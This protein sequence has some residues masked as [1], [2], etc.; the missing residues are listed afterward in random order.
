MV[1]GLVSEECESLLHKRYPDAL[2]V[3]LPFNAEMFNE[4]RRKRLAIKNRTFLRFW[5]EAAKIAIATYGD[6]HQEAFRRDVYIEGENI[7]SRLPESF[8]LAVVVD[9]E[10][11]ETET[12][13]H[14][15]I[16]PK[17]ESINELLRPKLEKLT[18]MMQRLAQNNRVAA[19]DIIL[20]SGKSSALPVVREVIEKCFA[21]A[22]IAPSRESDDHS[23]DLKECVVRGACELS[24][25]DP[26]AKV[27]INFKNSRALSA[28]T[29]RLG[30]RVSDTG[31][32]LFLEVVDAGVPIGSE[33]LRKPVPGIVLRRE[34]RI[35]LLENT[36]LED[37]IMLDGHVNPNITELRV[38]RLD[39]QLTEWEQ[40]HDRQISDED[41]FNT[42]IELIVTPNLLV[43][44][45]A[46]VP[47][48]EEPLEFEA[49][50]SGW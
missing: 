23:F 17:H 11:H 4:P 16:V 45:V 49:E 9:N 26:R 2:S 43:K 27:D 25:P 34:A 1:M 7:G 35:R 47:G 32:A 3:V 15:E 41:L 36:S 46:R 14:E 38:F 40:K 39:T 21:N 12:F 24:N 13:F 42:D 6:E 22:L 28:T 5:S 8:Q 44:L 20:L 31:Q 29:S 50:A 33:G 37:P 48:I 10:V 18:V 19:P 30:V